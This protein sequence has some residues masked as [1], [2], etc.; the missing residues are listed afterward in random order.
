MP[1]PFQYFNFPI[2]FCQ[3]CCI[4]STFVHNFDGHLQKIFHFNFPFQ[5]P[6]FGQRQL[7]Q[8]NNLNML[9]FMA[10]FML[11]FCLPPIFPFQLSSSSYPPP[12]H[13]PFFF[14]IFLATFPILTFFVLFIH[15]NNKYILFF[16]LSIF[17]C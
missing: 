10:I 4:Q 12:S 16:I 2:N 15:S 14:W 13:L 7:A 5:I 17:G 9:P 1:N 6:I 11:L 8:M 3:I